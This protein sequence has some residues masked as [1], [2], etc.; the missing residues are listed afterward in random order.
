MENVY[1]SNICHKITEQLRQAKESVQIAMAWFTRDLL[2]QSLLDCLKRKVKVELILQD[3]PTNFM[4]YAPDFNVFIQAGGEFRIASL[5]EFLHH[6]FC[7]IDRKV[8]ING[9]YNWTYSAECRN[10]ENI[11]ISDVVEVVSCF[12]EEFDKLS[13]MICVQTAS[14]RLTWEEVSQRDDVH[15]QEMNQ[16]IA[17]IC[18]RRELPVHKQVKSTATVQIVEVKKTPLAKYDI[19]IEALDAND[20]SILRTFIPKNKE[21]PFRSEVIPLYLNTS[22]EKFP[23]SL[24]YGDP[25]DQKTW[26]TIKEHNLREVAHGVKS[27]N[28][29]LLFSI[30]LDFDGGIRAEIECSESGRKI[31]ISSL[32]PELVKYE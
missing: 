9:S 20:D 26:I 23:C 5:S 19:G 28:L 21:L 1:F 7:I 24:I 4:E 8:V 18:E 10:I 15:Y 30:Y 12:N 13:D 14:P 17:Y 11:I 31:M 6:K 27:E 2:F 16:E 25:N 3:H 29:E 22:V 32:N